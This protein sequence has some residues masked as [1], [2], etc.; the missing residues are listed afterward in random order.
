IPPMRPGFALVAELVAYRLQGRPASVEALDDL[1]EPA[2]GLRREQPVRLR[3]RS[4]DVVDLP[5]G[6]VG[7]ADVPVLA[8]PIRAQDERPLACTNQYPY[9]THR[10]SLPPRPTA[11]ARRPRPAMVAPGPGRCLTPRTITCSRHPDGRRA[12]NSSPARAPTRIGPDPSLGQTI[13]DPWPSCRRSALSLSTS[14]RER[15]GARARSRR[16]QLAAGVPA[17]PLAGR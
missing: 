12:R 11:V 2:V 7:P 4:L 14:L 3:G 16:G 15:T 1:P 13:C 9:A 6:K 8:A 10:H 5:A 17:S